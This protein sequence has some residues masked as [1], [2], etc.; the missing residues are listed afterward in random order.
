MSNTVNP[1]QTKPD[2]QSKEPLIKERVSCKHRHFDKGDALDLQGKYW[3]PC[4]S[5]CIPLAQV[6][7]Y[8]LPNKQGLDVKKCQHVDKADKQIPVYYKLS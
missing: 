4:C 6:L 3:S 8:Q 7:N 1:V 2:I 5:T